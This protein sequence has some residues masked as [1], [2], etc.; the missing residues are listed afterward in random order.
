V[1]YTK[2]L[3]SFHFTCLC[4]YLALF[5]YVCTLIASVSCA[6]QFDT[7]N[8]KFCSLI[9]HN[10]FVSV[11]SGLKGMTQQQQKKRKRGGRGQ[12]SKDKTPTAESKYKV[13]FTH[14]S[15]LA[16]IDYLDL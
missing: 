3:I 12:G 2:A 14:F 7:P 5:C 11:P 4:M 15:R 16:L 13:R 8:S 1:R 6:L 9:D 10:L